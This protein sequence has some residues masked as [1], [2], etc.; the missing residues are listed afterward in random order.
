MSLPDGVS[1]RGLRGHSVALTD[2]V[3]GQGEALEYAPNGSGC[4]TM[5]ESGMPFRLERVA[6]Q[7]REGCSREPPRAPGSTPVGQVLEPSQPQAAPSQRIQ[8]LP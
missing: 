4:F 5:S 2:T 8:L 3:E 7:S 6:R 1:G